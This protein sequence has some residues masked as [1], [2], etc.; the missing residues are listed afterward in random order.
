[1]SGKKVCECVNACLSFCSGFMKILPKYSK[2]VLQAMNLLTQ[3]NENEIIFFLTGSRTVSA[4]TSIVFH[5]AVCLRMMKMYV[6]YCMVE[7]NLYVYLM[8]EIFCP[9][10]R[11]ISLSGCHI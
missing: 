2:S 7:K 6:R 11:L 9:I 10:S 8:S 1:M 3:I 5:S 4:T